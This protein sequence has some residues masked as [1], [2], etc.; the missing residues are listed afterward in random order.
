MVLRSLCYLALS[1]PVFA[2]PSGPE[3]VMA[4]DFSRASLV[5][6]RE[7]PV[8][9]PRFGPAL[10]ISGLPLGEEVKGKGL[11]F[12]GLP[13][14]HHLAASTAELQKILPTTE[15]T[16]AAWFSI[17][18]PQRYGAIFSALDDQ[19]SAEKG[20]ALGYNDTK[21]YVA[22]STKGADDGDGKLTY[23]TSSKPWKSG[24]VHQLVA[25]YD[26]VTLT[27]YLDGESVATT[28]EQKGEVLWPEDLQA[29][30]GGYRDRDEN[31]PHSGRLIDF[32]LYN[33]CA[34]PEWVKHD[35]EHHEELMRMPAD[36]PPPVEPAIVVKPYLQW[37]TQNEA[38]IRWETNF[39]CVGTVSWG[40][41]HT[42]GTEVMESEARLF[43]E[44]KIS[45][46][47]P[48]MLYY[49]RTSSPAE[50]ESVLISHRGTSLQTE[51]S[52]LQTANKPET[53]FGFVVLSDTQRQ[54]DVSG[55]LAKAAWALRPNFAVIAGDLVDAGNAKWQWEQQFFAS[56]D[57]LI[58]RVPFYPVLG[59]HEV[60]TDYYYE[61]MSL[62]APEYFY[63]YT[64]GN[65]QF[66]M[67]DTNR[68]V[69]P[70]TEQYTWL[71][72]ELAKSTARWKVCVHHQPPFSSDDDYG[73][74]WKAPIKRAT[75]GD[76][77]SKPLVALYDK[78]SVDLVWTGHVHSYERTWL[79]RNGKPVEKDG[80]LYMVTGGA[81]GP[82]ET[83][84]P[85]RPGFQRH[86]K[87][88]HHFCYVTV[89]GGEF[90]IKAYDLEGRLFDQVTLKKP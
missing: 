50:G 83:A 29:W 52:T 1:L 35:L 69:R 67:L 6:E 64:Y 5:T 30:L 15:F 62:P 77:K 39:P 28:P 58:S 42:C 87:R 63:T 61:Y 34:N 68:D 18:R 3:P 45:G 9:K 66:F 59:N 47:E 2:H 25:T 10:E 55:A 12:A 19:G 32:R 84:G 88:G 75:L 76:E 4:Y 17:D 80:T 33:A 51:V 38:T 89:H 40:E 31:Y 37:I 46:L 73:N 56:L 65:T 41:S 60:N 36:A 8:I 20:L 81:G 71:E 90:D 79:I 14:P 24:Q 11:R 43:H 26:G 72:S 13:Q 27:L 70:G 85:Y 78:Y 86:V 23:L 21:P 22:L 48:E 74:N 82:L 53:P 54:P 7:K 49:Y 44:V 16:L 57:P